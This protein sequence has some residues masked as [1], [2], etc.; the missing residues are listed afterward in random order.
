MVEGAFKPPSVTWVEQLFQREGGR[1]APAGTTADGR[2][3]SSGLV[4]T[5]CCRDSDLQI[6]PAI[7]TAAGEAA[8]FK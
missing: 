2:G 3:L 1:E 5:N 7:P 6:L 8:S 4:R